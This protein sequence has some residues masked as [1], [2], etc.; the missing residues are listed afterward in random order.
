MPL[1]ET[2]PVDESAVAIAVSKHWG[3]RLEKCVKSSQNHTYLAHAEGDETRKAFVRATPDP[4]GLQGR[5]IA[6]ELLFVNY[7]KQDA[8]L[9]GVCAPIRATDGSFVLFVPEHHLHIV[10]FEAA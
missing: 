3:F 4:K 9:E 1:F 7:L 5:K 8:K 6:D 10:I 2:L